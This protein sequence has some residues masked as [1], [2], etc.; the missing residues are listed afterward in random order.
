MVDY[1]VIAMDFLTHSINI[2]LLFITSSGMEKYDI[3]LSLNN[4][5]L[6]MNYDFF[7]FDV[8]IILRIILPPGPIISRILSGFI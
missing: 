1:F 3:L 4:K 6:V 2:S 7:C 8:R 5:L